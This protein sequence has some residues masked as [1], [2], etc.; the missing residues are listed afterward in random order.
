MVLRDGSVTIT[1]CG[2]TITRTVD[3]SQQAQ[4]VPPCVATTTTTALDFQ[5]AL[6]SQTFTLNTNADD[7]AVSATPTGDWLTATYSA[8]VVTTSVLE[9]DG[10]ERSGS[11]T[12][13]ACGGTITRTVTVAQSAAVIVPCFATAS[14]DELE[15]QSPESN[16]TFTLNTNADDVTV[17]TDPDTPWLTATYAA[18]VIT[19]SVEENTGVDRE[20]KITITACDGAVVIEIPVIQNAPISGECTASTTT[21]EI[22]FDPEIE[23]RQFTVATNSD[24]VQV[25]SSEP[26]WLEVSYDG[27]VVTAAT[28]STSGTDRSA[29]SLLQPVKVLR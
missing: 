17:E 20:C 28:L 24:A 2:G 10:P 5:P 19:A 4:V 3:V 7:V 16:Q 22:E 21:T 1:A 25:V 14:T 11:I 13:T 27:G 29:I 26:T 23:S 6:G 15:F 9:N 8:G 18:G 12:I